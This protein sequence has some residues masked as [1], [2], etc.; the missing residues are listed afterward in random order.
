MVQE[1]VVSTQSTGEFF[2]LYC[3]F[4][5]SAST[6]FASNYHGFVTSYVLF[7]YL[8]LI[9]LKSL[10]YLHSYSS[11]S[12]ARSFHVPSYCS[13]VHLS[14]NLLLPPS[15]TLTLSVCTSPISVA[16]LANILVIVSATVFSTLLMKIALGTSSMMSRR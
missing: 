1:A 8:S 13:F 5:V 9:R 15:G 16:L 11:I 7:A 10:Q 12:F 3:F 4:T 6:V 2:F 14:Q